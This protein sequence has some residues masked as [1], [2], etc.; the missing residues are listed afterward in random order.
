MNTKDYQ[1]IYRDFGSKNIAPAAAYHDTQATLDVASWK[2]LADTGFWRI[3]VPEEFGGLGGTM[4]DH[5]EAFYGLAAGCLDCGFM[6]SAAAHSGLIQLLLKSGS[7]GQKHSAVPRLLNGEIGATAATEST[8]GSH[9]SRT[10]TIATE[11]PDGYSV[12]G[13]KVHITNMP[14]AQ[15]CM[16]VG[17]IV[18]KE[19]SGI[20]L[21]LLQNFNQ[22]TVRSGPED[23]VGLRT[24]PLGSLELKDRFVHSSEIIGEPCNGL[25]ELYWCLNYDRILYGFIVAGFVSSLADAAVA[26]LESRE[27]FG[28]KLGRHQYMQERAVN[29]VRSAETCRALASAAATSLDQND[30]RAA[31]LGS[32]TKLAASDAVVNS[33]QDLVQIFGHSGCQ[34]ELPFERYFRDSIAFR[35]AG[36]T[37]E[38]QKKNVYKHLL[39]SHDARIDNKAGV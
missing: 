31:L 29:V 1:Q 10:N 35:I 39:I 14:V 20:T 26:R 21:F 18:S 17:R 37:D 36:G 33:T 7:P 15:I 6:L 12:S 8:G 2:R 4:T 24:S 13:T 38:M 9:V 11:R 3:G 16:V 27:A 22:S 5:Y 30:D 23:L 34:T 32:V 25:K 19:K 28:S